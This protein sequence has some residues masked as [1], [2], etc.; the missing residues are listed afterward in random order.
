M[1]KLFSSEHY[2]EY[3]TPIMAS[4]VKDGIPMMP[5]WKGKRIVSWA[6]GHCG[7]AISINNKRMRDMYR[8]GAETWH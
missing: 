4:C 5:F 6:C 8:N 7:I 2:M 3:A 1:S